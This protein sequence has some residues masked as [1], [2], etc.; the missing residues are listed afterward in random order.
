[1]KKDSVQPVYKTEVLLSMARHAPLRGFILI[2]L[3]IALAF[4]PLCA[5]VAAQ[6][7]AQVAQ[8]FGNAENYIKAVH[9][10]QQALEE[11]WH[12]GMRTYEGFHIEVA[13]QPVEGLSYEH[14]I[15]T[16]S[17]LVG[18]DEKTVVLHGGVLTHETA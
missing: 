18:G 16:V 6:L 17:F 8:Q 15:V 7:Q 13:T 14:R 9:Y 2:E 5:M 4:V 3:M 10:A 12:H 11:Q 1:M